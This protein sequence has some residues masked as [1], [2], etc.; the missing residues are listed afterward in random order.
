MKTRKYSK[1]LSRMLMS[2]CLIMGF[3]VISSTVAQRPAEDPEVGEWEVVRQKKGVTI[4][5]RTVFM[6][7]RTIF[8]TRAATNIHNGLGAVL[9]I[10]SGN[11][12]VWNGL[13]QAEEIRDFNVTPDRAFW[14]S[15]I[16]FDM[17]FPVKKQDL[18]IQSVLFVDPAKQWARIEVESVGEV[19][20]P[21]KGIK[22]M[23]KLQSV[24]LLQA[25]D[26]NTTRV[27]YQALATDKPLLPRWITDPIVQKTFV[28]LLD[29][30]RK[31][32]EAPVAST[33]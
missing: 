2:I 29:N 28:K 30:L 12:Q 31:T 21:Q 25:Q 7:N 33:N 32:G 10:M 11:S 8:E 20:P 15:Y 13:D 17:P 1:S 9:E 24:W 6:P 27:Q 14:N 16:L 5:K 22:R 19:I 3:C 18:V 26:A 4:A 23:R